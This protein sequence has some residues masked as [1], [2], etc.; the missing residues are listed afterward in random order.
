[1][2]DLSRF[3]DAQ[4]RDYDTALAEIKSG[5]KR[6]HWMWYIFPQ[7]QGLGRS[8]TA[9]YYAIRDL[10]EAV[11]YLN[12]PYLGKNLIEISQALLSIE[13]SSASQIFGSPDD[14]KL[15]SSMTLFALA[16]QDNQIF[17]EVLAKYYHGKMDERTIKT[18]NREK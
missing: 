18:I 7:I 5:R 2:Y 3:T 15:R 17:R 1:M 10:G 13:G 8:Q 12:D 14:M 11:A 4:K 9:Q 16:A 6:S